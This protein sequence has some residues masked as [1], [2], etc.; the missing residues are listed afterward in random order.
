M[1][2]HCSSSFGEGMM[3]GCN[4][5]EDKL[6]LFYLS[7]NAVRI[8]SFCSNGV[9]CIYFMLVVDIGCSTKLYY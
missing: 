8:P 5:E 6:Y 1:L 3:S 2:L 7:L 4:N 9:P